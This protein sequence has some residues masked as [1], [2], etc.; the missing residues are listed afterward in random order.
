[1]TDIEHKRKKAADLEGGNERS[2]EELRRETG[3]RFAMDTGDARLQLLIETLTELGVITEEQRLDFEI[4][5]HTQVE[6][7]LNNA[8]A[9]VRELKKRAAQP[10]LVVPGNAKGHGLIMPDGRK[11]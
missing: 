5:F 7:A 9:Q 8:W 10:Q 4:K 11:V 6:E 1:M 2:Y 3:G